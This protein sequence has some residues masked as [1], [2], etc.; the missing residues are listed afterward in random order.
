MTRRSSAA[1][2]HK[3]TVIWRLD[4]RSKD[5]DEQLHL[6]LARVALGHVLG[7]AGLHGKP[8]GATTDA[9]DERV[10]LIITFERTISKAEL[11]IGS[12]EFGAGIRI[13]AVVRGWTWHLL[14]VNER[15]DRVEIVS[16]IVLLVKRER[17]R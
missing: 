12:F 11:D 5:L 16:S 1:P 4:E 3:A 17:A 6:L 10:S 7:G 8:S 15:E 14:S 2:D 9:R 13:V